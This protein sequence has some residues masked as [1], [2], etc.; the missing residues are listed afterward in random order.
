MVIAAL[1]LACAGPEADTNPEVPVA[2]PMSDVAWLTRAS[3]DLRGVRPTLDEIAT[4]EAD[5]SAVDALLDQY[6]HDPRF[7][8]RVRDMYAEIFLTRYDYYTI[9]AYNYGLSDDAAF[10]AAVGEETLQIV[11]TIAEQDLPY[12][13]LV[14]GDWTMAN[15]QLAAA[16]PLD[17]PDGA[18][19]WRQVHYTDG[20]PSAGMLATNSLWWRYP[21]SSNNANRSRANATSRILLCHDY[22]TRPIGFDRN[23]NI[24]DQSAI[25]SAMQTNEACVNCHVSLEPLAGYFYGFYWDGYTAADSSVYH[26]ERERMYRQL[27]FV[28]PG[29]Y[30]QAGYSLEDLGQ[31]LAADPR[32]PQCA[33]QQAYKALLRRDLDLEDED[34][35]TA[36]REAF[37]AGGLTLRSLYASILHD[38]RYRAGGD[39]DAPADVPVKLVTP[40]MLGSQIEDL[41]GYHWKQYGYDM[42]GTDVYGVRTLA[43]GADGYTVTRTATSPNAT[44]VMVGARLAE[45]AA[46]HVISQ[47]MTLPSGDRKLFGAID[48]TET[49][50]IGRDAMVA[51][52]QALHL[53]LYGHHVA[54]DG[55]EVAANLGLWSELFAYDQDPVGAWRG[56]LTALLRDPDLLFY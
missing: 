32:F 22:L 20:R 3:L 40:D 8:G 1:W 9:R 24:L 2:A 5:P 19:G 11:S 28:E 13:E 41:T 47:D 51:Q 45:A 17:Y 44:S 48:F 25:D 26:P 39:T 27:N 46:G 35:I 52:L 12:T 36:H 55:P 54:A 30:G 42:L 56:V 16:W 34:Q 7:G 49:P 14:T 50:E 37:L 43:G 31:Q 29:Y 6:L 21:T 53:R 10:N 18:T 4:V 23:V 15:E 33:V 38:P